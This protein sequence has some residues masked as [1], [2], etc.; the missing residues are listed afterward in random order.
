[1][2]KSMPNFLQS[3]GLAVFARYISKNMQKRINVVK[4]YTETVAKPN[5]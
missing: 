1:M 3:I 2:I 4:M 5:M